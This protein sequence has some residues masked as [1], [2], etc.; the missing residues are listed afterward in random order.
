MGE[1]VK[2]NY[3]PG[4]I[5]IDVEQP[6]VVNENPNKKWPTK[7][8][9]I[10]LPT[11]L[12]I[13]LGLIAVSL[14]LVLTESESTF[15]AGQATER[16]FQAPKRATPHPT[17]APTSQFPSSSPTTMS[18]TPS[19]T[20]FERG[21]REFLSQQDGNA[22]RD[23][24]KAK[25]AIDWLLEEAAVAQSAISPFNQKFLQR[26]GILI[27]YFSVFTDQNTEPGS[28]NN[29]TPLPNMGMQNQNECDWEGMTCDE[30]GMLTGIK[31]ANRQLDGSLPSEWSF[32]PN[33]KSI[34]FYKNTL[35]GSIPEEL[36]DLVGLEQVFLYH[37]QF[38]GSISSKIGQLWNL[39]NFDVSHN[40]LS[41]SLPPE[42][43]SKGDRIRQIRYF[44]I[45]RNQMTGVIPS[46]MRLRQMFYMDLGFN[47]ISGTLPQEFGDQA[48]RLRHLFLDHNE[49]LGTLPESYV[50]AGQRRIKTLFVNDNNLSGVFP[51]N[52]TLFQKM[53]ELK[54]TNNHFDACNMG[55]YP[56]EPRIELKT[57]CDICKC[58]RLFMCR[59]CKDHP[60]RSLLRHQME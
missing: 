34:E 9:M 43:S 48:V 29:N 56:D 33:L 30:N 31:L 16:L 59:F 11:L 15:P 23:V 36:F 25:K 49:F 32:F 27:L 6:S 60:R 22:N 39:T 54:T 8:L 35:Q 38:T 14:F 17:I 3:E 19:P 1:I 50:V 51:G 4:C 41:G 13:I 46:N 52:A 18:P 10:A 58:R 20:G 47:R 40:K 28:P 12:V 45:H 2:S 7:Y 24:E 44:N 57:D 37:N 55:F 53:Q 26:Y 42:L 5:S 21:I